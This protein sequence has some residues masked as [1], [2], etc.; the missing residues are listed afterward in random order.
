MHIEVRRAEFHEVETLRD[1]YR[2]EMDCQLIY[3]AALPRGWADAYLIL[4]EGRVAGYGAIL[5][6]H[7]KDRITEFYALPAVRGFARPMFRELIAAGQATHIAAQT[8]CPTILFMLYEFATGIRSEKILFHDAALTH[9][10]CP[11]GVFRPA[12][13]EDRG[14]DGEWVIEAGG[15][16]VASGDF[17]CHY[18]PPYGDIYMKVAEPARRRGFGSYLVQELKRVCYE[19]GK[20]PSARCDPSNAASRRTLRK[21]GLLPCGRLLVG[22][23]S[24]SA[25]P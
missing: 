18:N 22:E 9:L 15:E 17:L 24:R 1:L 19:A 10:P 2:Q 13:P 20:K 16:A 7:D 21:A 8:N 12:V 11:D 14:I 6:R 3:D 4:A 5:N 25:S 23:V